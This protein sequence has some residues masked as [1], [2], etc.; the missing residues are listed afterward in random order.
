MK[1]K[2]I[3]ILI[4]VITILT[5]SA[6]AQ[7][8]NILNA[9]HYNETG[10]LQA[11]IT[12][13]TKSLDGNYTNSI[14]PNDY[15]T[16]SFDG[17]I[18]NTKDITISAKETYN[19]TSD[20]YI[21]VYKTITQEYITS[22]PI[23]QEEKIYR[24]FLTNMTGMS[25]E[26][27]LK[28]KSKT[29]NKTKSIQ[30]DLIQDPAIDCTPFFSQN[31]THY[32]VING[33][34]KICN[35]LNAGNK[36]IHIT[37][38]NFQIDVDGLNFNTNQSIE[39]YGG[40]LTNARGN[41]PIKF[42]ANKSIIINQTLTTAGQGGI[43]CTVS[44]INRSA[45]GFEFTAK[46]NI[47][48]NGDIKATGG[49]GTNVGCSYRGGTANRVI[50]SANNI[51]T[52][53][54]K[55]TAGKGYDG[56]SYPATSTPGGPAGGVN[57]TST[58]IMNIGFINVTSGYGGI[59]NGVY[60]GAR[61]G[62]I[63]GPVSII[64]NNISLLGI[65][66][67]AGSGGAGTSGDK[68]G[69][70]SYGYEITGN[71]VN[72]LNKVY[73]RSGNGGSAAYVSSTQNAG[74]ILSNSF[75]KAINLN[76]SDITL[77]GGSSGNPYRRN[78]LP[79][80]SK[81]NG[82]STK[83]LI[84][85]ATNITINGDISI[86][87]GNANA[88]NY[89]VN[90]GDF[91]YG[92]K[93]GKAG[94]I[95][96]IS[97]ILN[98]TGNIFIIGGNGG[99][100]SNLG[101][102]ATV[103]TTGNITINS[104][105][106]TQT[107]NT[108]IQ[109][110]NAGGVAFCSGDYKEPGDTG[111]INIISNT[112]IKTNNIYLQGGNAV[113]C[114]IG[115][116]G[117]IGKITINPNNNIQLNNI[118]MTGGNGVSGGNTGNISNLQ[119]T[120]NNNI[121]ANN[122]IG[123][124]IGGNININTN[125]L[126]TK[127][128]GLNSTTG[129]AGNIQIDTFKTTGNNIYSVATTGNAGT[130]N[131]NTFDLTI[132]ESI[133]ATSNND[134][135]GTTNIKVLNKMNFINFPTIRPTAIEGMFTTN[136]SYYTTQ[137]GTLSL[138]NFDPISKIYTYS[139]AN[140]LTNLLLI[141]TNNLIIT[142]L[143]PVYTNI[144]LTSIKIQN[145]S[146][147]IWK[148]DQ[149]NIDINVTN[150]GPQAENPTLNILIDGN[151]YITSQPII[152]LIP[153]ETRTIP[154]NWDT[155]TYSNTNHTIQAQINI[156]N[157]IGLPITGTDNR[158]VEYASDVTTARTLLIFPDT[159]ITGQQA[160]IF[161]NYQNTYPLTPFENLKI[162]IDNTNTDY[163]ITNPNKQINIPAG[164]IGSEI[165]NITSNIIGEYPITG[166]MGNNELTTTSITTFKVIP[167]K[168]LLYEDWETNSF[169]THNWTII[170]GITNSWIIS[171]NQAY[172]GTY[173]SRARNT[174]SPTIIINNIS[175]ESVA[176]IQLNYA[177]RYNGLDT[178]QGEYFA[179][180][181]YNGTNWITL[182]NQSGSSG[183]WQ[184][185]NYILGI[186][187]DNNPNFK[188]KFTCYNNLANENC[189]T[190]NINITALNTPPFPPLNLYPPNNGQL[191]YGTNNISWTPSFDAE[192]DILTYT[193]EINTG[194]GWTQLATGI[195]TPYYI[196]N[197]TTYQNTTINYRIYATDTYGSISDVTTAMNINLDTTSEVVKVQQTYITP[198]TNIQKNT[199]LNCNFQVNST[200][201]NQININ[202]TWQKTY[203]NINWQNV[204]TYDV[205]Y[206]NINQ[207]QLY[208]TSTGI[209][210]VT[211]DLTGTWSWKCIIKANN[212]AYT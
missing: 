54:I 35:T 88:A 121:T 31:A 82:G 155:T 108:Y 146:K 133:Y 210:S 92:G 127:N 150:N 171:T 143:P 33:G 57:I 157:N 37:N 47:F 161:Y 52:G 91:Y 93:S 23:I 203:N 141:R 211:E 105:T 115:K 111:N 79:G 30:I 160:Q 122:I 204:T 193:I 62:D 18:D 114:T 174:D 89:N 173:S 184:T 117:N 100:S 116:G 191:N 17:L 132:N 4:L 190:D 102:L 104:P 148:G 87:S 176:K 156:P 179:T 85:N 96:I 55:L 172:A 59:G 209:G 77:I 26:F 138:S 123:F 29:N 43:D 126:K 120:T 14:H 65:N 125:T 61:G 45:P 129:T 64:G 110:G 135:T 186:D 147:D 80:G 34:T 145:L 159:I 73:S 3:F 205:T 202:I 130:I 113:G 21:E 24:I 189:R 151:P 38:T 27:D 63:L 128:I 1:I 201:P 167:N 25:N 72:I 183:G 137:Y 7:I 185:T 84:I 51:T 67:I 20:I 170:P 119:L 32:F 208:T 95:D 165:Y 192:N 46:N 142:N 118:Y 8:I 158:K 124:G 66:I 86:T 134:L 58:T 199:I 112:N 39:W 187:A 42:N 178:G 149:I 162:S 83:N 181:Y 107:G 163:T 109:A 68:R 188:I 94:N 90:S 28:L 153:G 154:I 106:I 139:Y 136:V 70:N 78:C 98:I 16:V 194:T 11:D 50:L 168:T 207:N 2:K 177:Y 144:T 49:G 164:Y 195:T 166:I 5:I 10:H 198:T 12:N 206:P 15:I 69:G 22:F 75:L 97:N 19:T 48:I 13:L 197:I 40:I 99:S 182:F 81:C 71:N 212:G 60:Q 180:S 140:S 44:V 53:S 169:L 56:N 152:N 196:W 103:Q 131:I 74:N 36:G 76:I 9:K 175:T 101:Q 6:N 200:N 41:I